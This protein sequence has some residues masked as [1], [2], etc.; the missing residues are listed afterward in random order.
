MRA[1]GA[2]EERATLGVALGLL[3]LERGLDVGAR[4]VLV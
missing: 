1:T 2:P 4:E 3:D